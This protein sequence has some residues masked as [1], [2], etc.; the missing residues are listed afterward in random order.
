M[1]GGGSL[2][3]R[4][5]EQT[6]NG[7]KINGLWLASTPVWTICAAANGAARRAGNGGDRRTDVALIVPIGEHVVHERKC[8][9]AKSLAQPR[10]GQRDEKQKRRAA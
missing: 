8:D 5:G 6:R 3:R 9:F 2:C 7:Q 4:L 1:E 10:A